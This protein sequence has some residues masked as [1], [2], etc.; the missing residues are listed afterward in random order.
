M[1]PYI[2]PRTDICMADPM[3]FSQHWE[4]RVPIPLDQLNLGVAL[5]NSFSQFKPGDL[6]QV[7][8][9]AD[10]NYVRLCETADFRVVSCNSRKIEAIQITETIKVPAI[11]PEDDPKSQQNLQ[12]VCIRGAFEVQ[13]GLGNVIELFVDEQQ[14][15]KFI[16]DY[17]RIT[18]PTTP[19]RPAVE[20]R[21]GWSVKKSVNGKWVV[22]NAAGELV[23]EFSRRDEAEAFIQPVAA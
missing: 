11:L 13:D 10:K 23:K 14:A 16:E 7:T 4:V 3:P 1:A 2:I 18:A 21:S 6:I 5:Q 19:A 20:D 8:S 9:F 17:K 12:I 15:K 22:R